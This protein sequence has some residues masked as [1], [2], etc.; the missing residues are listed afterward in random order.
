MV[1]FNII[2]RLSILLF[3][4]L[5]FVNT[6]FSQSKV[7]TFFKP[8]DTLNI[9]RRN[10]VI[11]FE[12][13]VFVGGIIQLNKIFNKDQFSSNCTFINDNSTCLQMDKA[14]HI[15]TSYQIGNMSYNLLNWAGVSKK[16]KLIY[17][18]GMGFVFLTTAEV[19]DGFSKDSNASYGDVLANAG[20]TSLF[21]FQDLLWDEQRIVPK[22][23][24]HSSQF[25]SSN[26][27]TMKTQIENE[28][29]GQ[30][31]WLSANI[32]SFF[33]KSKVPNFLNIAIGYG[34][35]NLDKSISNTNNEPY[36]QLFLSLDVDLTRIKTKSHF[37]KTVFSILNCIKVPAP[38]IEFSRN[39]RVKGYLIYF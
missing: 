1:S 22:F 17:G 15:F 18:A 30:T 35:E 21:V 19:L 39:N 10:S 29:D 12:S 33:K 8:S 2:I 28:F 3:Y 16:N 34:V 27:K 20:G 6:G 9:P 4:I 5:L 37:L 7:N 31:F 24:F 25:I 23:S 11:I 14:A 32:H 26:I 13:V 36:R 38:T